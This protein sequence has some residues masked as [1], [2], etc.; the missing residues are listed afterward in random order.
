MDNNK[1]KWCGFQFNVSYEIICPC[2]KQDNSEEKTCCL[3]ECDNPVKKDS[4]V[5]ACEEHEQEVIEMYEE[6][7][8]AN[9]QELYDWWS[10]E[11]IANC[12]DG[13][14]QFYN[15]V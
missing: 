3:C 13:M 11:C 9:Q 8:H 2:C 6:E 5:N 14:K 12:Y 7:Y 10:T 4:K 15:K 1:C